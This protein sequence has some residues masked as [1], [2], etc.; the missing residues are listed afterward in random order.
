MK[1]IRA[2][3]PGCALALLL[4]SNLQLVGEEIEV[5]GPPQPGH[6]RPPL[7][8]NVHPATAV[9]YTPA[10][11]RH[12]YGF[13][14]ITG[15][16]SGQT[17]AIV[18]AYG[19]PDIQSD[20]VAFDQQFGLPAANLQVIG[21]TG[22]NGGWALETALDV[23]WA[24][25]IAPGANLLLSVAKSASNNDLLAAVDAAV[26]NGATVVSMSWGGSEFGG[27][28]ADDTHFNVPGVT[29]VA[30]AGDSSEGVEWPAV[31]PYVLSV[32][33][34]SLYLDGSN[35]RSA[36]TAWSGSGGGLS[37][38][39]AQPTWQAG[40]FAPGWPSVRGVPDVGY[41]ADPNT[42]VLVYDAYNGGWYAVGG[43]SVGAPQWAATIALVNQ[44]RGSSGT[45]SGAA[46][47][48]Y[49]VAQDSAT[50]PYAINP[51]YFYDVTQGN[52]GP[53]PDDLAGPGYDLVTG[54]G[55]PVAN[56]LVGALGSPTPD[57]SLSVSPGSLSVA[58]GGSA[59]YT[60][61]VSA[62]GGFTGVVGL[63]ISGLPSGATASFNPGSVTGSG[64]ATLTITTSGATPLGTSTLTITGSSGTLTHTV[65]VTLAVAT[66]DFSISATP[67]SRTVRHGHS[68][69]YTVTV[70]PTGGFTGTVG[71]SV[72]GLPSGASAS[73]KPASI[74]TSGSSTMTVSTKTNAARGTFT[75]TITGASG[76]LIRSTTVTLTID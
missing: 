72:S 60:V 69:S 14:Q 15:D 45:L 71:L 5:S 10:Q 43:T 49:A 19:N 27:E 17:I 76:S 37:T 34:T 75:L 51:T 47:A 28:T 38:V 11:I 73:F 24:H 25:A 20:L 36:E 12:A 1:T 53:D 59:T 50:P 33:G 35:N 58:P 56:N 68:T 70:T 41:V 62:S 39:Y 52:N 31:S 16:G 61:T 7:H 29:F 55:T 21:V 64:G 9:Y 54:I 22:A 67:T 8:V 65:N 57:F 13:D 46:A 40:W 18:D 3:R 66:P 2:L 26:Q 74:A 63:G 23:E 6:A 44:Q 30:S 42:A 48:L 4:A 32:G